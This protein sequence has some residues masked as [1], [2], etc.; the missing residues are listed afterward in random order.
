MVRAV[1][2]GLDRVRANSVCEVVTRAAASLD[3][4]IF[5][6]YTAAAGDASHGDDKSHHSFILEDKSRQFLS[7]GDKEVADTAVK[8]STAAGRPV[9]RHHS[10]LSAFRPLWHSQLCDYLCCSTTSWFD[11]VRLP[12]QGGSKFVGGGAESA[13]AVGGEVCRE[14]GLLLA[15]EDQRGEAAV[16]TKTNIEL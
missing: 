4:S 5:P 16:R 7:T 14:R 1:Y 11:G 10:L 15:E 8:K 6:S 12:G 2:S 13:Q 3:T 9:S